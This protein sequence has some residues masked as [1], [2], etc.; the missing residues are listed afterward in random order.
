M[1]EVKN[2]KQHSGR[3]GCSNSDGPMG[4]HPFSSRSFGG[5]VP[6]GG[7]SSGN[8]NL[9]ALEGGNKKGDKRSGDIYDRRQRY[10]KVSENKKAAPED[11]GR[12]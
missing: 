4:F 1:E 2:G 10:G 3:G 7:I 6:K 8:G 9:A 12:R 11:K 5:A